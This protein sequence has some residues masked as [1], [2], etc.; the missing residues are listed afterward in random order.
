MLILDIINALLEAFVLSP[1]NDVKNTL[2][3]GLNI[4][5]KISDGIG[6]I[7]LT[8]LKQII[9]ETDLSETEIK[10]ALFGLIQKGLVF[11]SLKL[12]NGEFVE[13]FKTIRRVLSDLA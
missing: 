1:I 11:V 8:T 6:V 2:N 7:N 5:L 4:V 9:A 12:E 3:V 10:K 13:D